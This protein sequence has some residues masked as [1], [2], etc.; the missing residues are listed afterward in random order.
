MPY[1]LTE[2][3]RIQRTL[4]GESVDLIPWATR[5]DIWHTAQTRGGALPPDL[6]GMDLMEIHRRLG[7]GRQGYARLTRMKLHGVDLRVTFNGAVIDREHAPVLDFPISRASV[8][9]E[10]PGE[11]ELTFRTPAGTARL[12]FGTNDILI[13]EAAVPY[14][15]KHIVTDDDDFPA[16]Q[17][18]VDHAEVV[19]SYEEFERVEQEIG[20]YGFT[21]GMLGRIPFQ[22]I[23][24]DYLG[25]EMTVFTMLDN[26]P[27]F[28]HLLS[29]LG[30]HVRHALD[31]GL[32][33]PAFMLEFGDNFE[34]S[35][36]SPRFFRDY[37]MAFLQ[38]AADRVH[39]AG[40]VLGSHMDGNM[41]PLLHLVPECG[42]DVVESFSPWP[43]TALTFED[44]WSAWRG[45]V[46]TWG[47]VP[48]P[49]FEPH[50][51]QLE[52]ETWLDDMFRILDGD[53]R[54]ILGIGDQ[55]LRP[56]ILD[57]VRRVSSL[58]GRRPA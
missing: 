23:L 24:L 46:L 47:V 31:L 40:R 38:E 14:V 58:L 33:S 44:A 7:I 11:T 4:R 27:A 18:I 12:R 48:S 19:P 52:F 21:I 41:K 39:A 42:V 5:L 10:T 35:I 43:L 13:R 20:D 28:D 36:T 6:A 30:E 51:S 54:I 3:E 26:R 8:P 2:R 57:R 1:S 16:V 34:G 22:Q 9:A 53:R 29:A 50:V 37:C 56:T 25:E 32:A 55:A 15:V 45:K 49:I 17:W